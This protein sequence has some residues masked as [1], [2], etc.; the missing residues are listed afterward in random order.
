[1]ELTATLPADQVGDDMH[2]LLTAIEAVAQEQ[3]IL[4]RAVLAGPDAPGRIRCAARSLDP[5]RH[6]AT[7]T[8]YTLTTP[9][10]ETLTLCS[11]A[12]TVSWLCREGLPADVEARQGTTPPGGCMTASPGMA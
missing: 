5:S 7:T 12:C 2:A 8:R 3:E 9:N 11:A 4:S 6:Y 1:M 10:D